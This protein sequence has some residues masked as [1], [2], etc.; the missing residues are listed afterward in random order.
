MPF[1][2]PTR[3]AQ[4]VTVGVADYLRLLGRFMI[5]FAN[6]QAVKRRISQ[7]N[8]PAKGRPGRQPQSTRPE[9]RRNR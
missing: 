4:V 7:L 3:P 8:R 1:N 5:V 2:A 6:L 9:H